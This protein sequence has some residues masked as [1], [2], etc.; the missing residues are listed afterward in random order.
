MFIRIHLNLRKILNF[1]K[2]TFKIT[3]LYPLILAL[4]F[5]AN[6]NAQVLPN[7]KQLPSLPDKEGFAG[8]LGGVS[9][10]ELFCMGGA[11]F[12]EKR[13]WEGGKKKWYDQIYKLEKGEKW[14][15]LKQKMPSPSAYG[16]S[17]SY[18]DN[19]IVVGG[20]DEIKHSN[21]VTAYKWTGDS[22]QITAFPDLPE[23]LSNM[24]GTLVN[25]LIII[26]GGNN[27]PTSLP[28]RKCFG[29][30]LENPKLGW[31]ELP[32]ISGSERV[33]PICASYNGV[34]YLFSGEAA[35]MTTKNERFRYILQDGYAF[36]PIKLKDKWT[37]SWIPLC[38]LPKGVSAAGSPLPVLN[39]G[40]IVFWG[41]VDAITALHKDP[42]THK[43]INQEVFMY[44]IEKDNWQYAGKMTDVAARVTLPVVFW[45]GQ[46]VYLSGEI[47]P[48]VRT[49]TVYS[50]KD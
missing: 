14:I 50:I 22:M 36:T 25:S 42:A 17:V 2:I 32:P 9:K 13:P 10:G 20:S 15:E 24:A 47:K 23:P 18:Q 28:L 40:T 49:N 26:A 45:N 43:G 27:T 46:W 48:G 19:I 37:G 21:K 1:P 34:F 38:P 16:V 31:F 4:F 11:N 6:L 39:N 41:G 33:Q 30:D 5:M 7:L 3:L 29:F 8:M 44:S 12:P 35:W